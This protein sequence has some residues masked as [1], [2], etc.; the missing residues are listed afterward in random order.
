MLVN[1]NDSMVC[2][3]CEAVAVVGLV[4][5]TFFSQRFNKLLIS[6]VA[7]SSSGVFFF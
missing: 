6:L 4:G 2:C 7:V 1:G 5:K 3:T